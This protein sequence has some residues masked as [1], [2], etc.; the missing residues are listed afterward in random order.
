VFLTPARIKFR[1]KVKFNAWVR[2]WVR[3]DVK[4]WVRVR[5]RGSRRVGV[6]V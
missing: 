2:L 6:C 4:D 3:V 1:V 5:V